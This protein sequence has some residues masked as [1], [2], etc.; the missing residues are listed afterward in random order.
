MS[1][2][3]KTRDDAMPIGPG[4]ICTFANVPEDT[5]ITLTGFAEGN[6]KEV[7]NTGPFAL[8]VYGAFADGDSYRFAE[9]ESERTAVVFT[10]RGGGFLI[11]AA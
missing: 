3:G 5:G 7:H 9:H 1:P 2:T 10:M 6:S 4:G 11:E 8:T